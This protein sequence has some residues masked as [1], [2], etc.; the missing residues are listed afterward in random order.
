MAAP[1][2]VGP[3]NRLADYVRGEN[4]FAYLK[5]AATHDLAKGS[6]SLRCVVIGVAGT[7]AKFYDIPP[8]G[9][10]A[11]ANQIGTV[12]TATP[13]TAP[14]IYFGDLAFSEGLVCVT[15][16]AGTELTVTFRGGTAPRRIIR[17]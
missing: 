2:N 11:D 13:A 3:V 4:D 9:T 5:G 16:G 12:D 7:T 15:V 8:G 6:G 14:Y 17:R 10:P 1:T